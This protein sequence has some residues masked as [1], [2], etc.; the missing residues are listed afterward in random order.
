[1]SSQ[2]DLEASFE[3]TLDFCRKCDVR[4]SKIEYEFLSPENP[5]SVAN[6]LNEYWK[7]NP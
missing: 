5:N 3:E 4:L 7:I 2:D 1:M 6:K